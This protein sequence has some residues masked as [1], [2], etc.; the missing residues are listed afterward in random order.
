MLGLAGLIVAASAIARGRP[1]PLDL[2]ERGAEVIDLRDGER[3]LADTSMDRVDLTS[4]A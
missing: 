3:G 1:D 4:T 2:S